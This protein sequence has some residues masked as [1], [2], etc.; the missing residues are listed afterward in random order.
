MSLFLEKNQRNKTKH[1]KKLLG[2][3]WL[4]YLR[5]SEEMSLIPGA[6]DM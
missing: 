1:I 3:I 4:V 2:W 5:V 6:H